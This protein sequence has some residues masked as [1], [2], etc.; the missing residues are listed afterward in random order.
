MNPNETTERPVVRSIA[1]SE[2]ASCI[3]TS[4]SVIESKTFKAVAALRWRKPN[5][6][7]AIALVESTH[8]KYAPVLQQAWQCIETGELDWRDVPLVDFPN[9]ASEGRS[10]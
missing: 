8:G 7:E 5:P 4:V 6:N 1:C 9:V 3:A 10:E 2:G